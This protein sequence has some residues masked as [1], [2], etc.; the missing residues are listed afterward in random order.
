MYD[1]SQ[2]HI[3][4]ANLTNGLALTALCCLSSGLALLV[5]ELSLVSPQLELLEHFSR[6][7]HAANRYLV[8]RH[9]FARALCLR[10][11]C[12]LPLTLHA[13]QSFVLIPILRT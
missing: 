8:Q 13:Q 1:I 11:Q 7:L 2:Q 3:A 12:F 5:P 10:L 4:R 9:C 6:S